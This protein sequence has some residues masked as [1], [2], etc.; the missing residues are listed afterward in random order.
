MTELANNQ[1]PKLARGVRLRFDEARDGWMLLAP[2][3]AVKLDK[4][5]ASILQAVDGERDF[6]AV[7]ESLAQD[8]NAPKEQIEGDV[9]QFLTDLM[10]K[11]MVEI[12][13]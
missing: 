13:P 1:R 5:A 12:A 8:F 2:E 10:N 7:V 6:A 4:I 11:R 3:R 9:R